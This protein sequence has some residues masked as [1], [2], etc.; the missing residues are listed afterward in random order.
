MRI[1]VA[2]EISNGTPGFEL[3]M[4][5][6]RADVDFLDFGV[7]RM[8]NSRVVP[9]QWN[10]VVSR[11][12]QRVYR[13][14]FIGKPP[15]LWNPRKAL[16]RNAVRLLR[17]S[18]HGRRAFRLSPLLSQ[19]RRAEVPI[20]GVDTSD[21]P[22]IDNSRFAILGAADLFFKRELP[23]NPANAFLYT[24]DRTEDTGNITRL[25]FFSANVGKL[26]PVSLGLNDARYDRLAAHQREK[27]IDVFFAG[28]VANRPTR[29]LGLAQLN[30]LREQGF[31]VLASDA[32]Y[33]EEEYMALAGRAL[34]SWSPEGFGFDCNRTYEVAGAGSVPLLKVSPIQAYAPFTDTVNALFYTHEG[35][36]LY[37]ATAAALADRGRLVRMGNQA[38]EHVQNHHRHSVLAEHLVTT[39]LA[40]RPR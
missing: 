8:A 17:Y 24:D 27:D 13:A 10:E 14:A 20:A 26:R 35:H 40:C 30:R 18:T 5:S 33:P 31:R 16:L 38:R 12:R 36:D 23:T 1:L 3:E 9:L 28:A 39:L 32:P 15:R 34:I 19:L 2:D 29:A 21:A 22:I 11:I 37:Q 7:G 25:P 4:F 6:H